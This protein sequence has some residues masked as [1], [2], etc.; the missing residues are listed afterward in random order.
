MSVR[1]I[2]AQRDMLGGA[3]GAKVSLRELGDL[4]HV[5]ALGPRAG[6]S[7]ESTVFDGQPCIARV[8][9]GGVHVETSADTRHA[10]CFL[11]YDQVH[12]WRESVQL[13]AIDDEAALMA[14]VRRVAGESGLDDETP[15]IFLLRAYAAAMTFHV[16]DKRD[17]LPHTPALHERA[18]VR[19]QLERR[20]VDVLGFYSSRH[21]GIFTPG[22]SDL[23]MHF[24]TVDGQISGHVERI[25][26]EP[27][28]AVAVPRKE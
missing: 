6:A 26:L 2:G 27:G 8:V 7:G 5:Y 12:A 19:F 11:V 1:W 9:D 18:K 23:H 10:A 28:T 22:D 14:T 16:L 4:P 17:G 3:G 21:R 24:R 15:F 13:R 25:A 20:E